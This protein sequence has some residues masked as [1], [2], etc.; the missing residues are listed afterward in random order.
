LLVLW[1]YLVAEID[2]ARAHPFI[3]QGFYGC[4][5]ELPDDV[6]RRGLWSKK[7]RPGRL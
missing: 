1:K 6:L 4:C 7:P 5:I 3:G 2:Q